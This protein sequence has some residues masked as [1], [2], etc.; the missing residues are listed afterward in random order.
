MF[1]R[2]STFRGDM[3]RLEEG[4]TLFREKVVP[5]DEKLPGFAGALLLADRDAGLSY[6]VTFW[7][8]EEAMT[9][10]DPLGNE[11]AK[12]AA[13]EL[14]LTVEIGH[15]EVLISKLPALVA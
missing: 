3:A 15:S 1:A 2:I 11:L 9:A 8:T 12:T 5:E 6:A 4:K 13:K 10:S 14:G 7:E